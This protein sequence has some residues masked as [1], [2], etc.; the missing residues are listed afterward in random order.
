MLLHSSAWDGS[1]CDT[2]QTCCSAGPL[3]VPETSALQK[4]LSLCSWSEFTFPNLFQFSASF[5]LPLF[6]GDEADTP[7]PQFRERGPADRAIKQAQTRGH[8]TGHELQISHESITASCQTSRALLPGAVAQEQWHCDSVT[9]LSTLQPAWC[10]PACTSLSNTLVHGK[11]AHAICLNSTAY[12]KRW[13]VKASGRQVVMWLT[14][15]R[16]KKI[17]LSSF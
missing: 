17:I 2:I 16:R 3:Q 7:S 5:A 10:L 13:F 8:N 1:I 15:R 14:H 11:N 9:L 4:H 12:A 6:Q